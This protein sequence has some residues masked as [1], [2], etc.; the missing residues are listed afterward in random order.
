MDGEALCFDL[1]FTNHHP[2]PSRIAIRDAVVTHIRQLGFEGEVLAYPRGPAVPAPGAPEA[3]PVKA[4]GGAVPGMN[5]K[6]V[7][8]HGGAIE[9]KA[10]PGVSHIVAVASGKGGVG[11]S[12]VSTNLA[13]A[14]QRQG[15]KVGLLDLDV[16]GPSLPMMMNVNSRPMVDADR[17]IVPVNSYGVK[18][19]S[20]GLL[21]P[22]DQ[23]MIWRGPMIMGVLR[24]FVQDTLWGELDYMIVDL[25][26][27]TGDA[28]LSLVQSVELAGAVIVTTP[29]PVAL[30]DAIRGISMFR[31]LD[32]PLLGLVEN[33]AWY[34]LPDGQRDYVFGEDGGKR[35]AESNE[36]ELLGQIPLQTSLRASCDNGIPV[37]LGEGPLAD[38]FEHIAKRVA[39]QLPVTATA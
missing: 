1:H 3:P 7:V 6:G 37:A 13:V 14:L 12:T 38:A 27:G 18:C 19:M 21:V 20:I 11:K 22:A 34:E 28:Q 5:V 30:A 16:Y 2:E 25:P 35:T 4:K 10:L 32:V 29:Q 39:A 15:Y 31:K 23:A 36:T 8:P 24:Q 9:K 17:K 26:P 33:M